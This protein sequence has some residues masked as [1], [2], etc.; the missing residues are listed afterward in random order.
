MKLM[1]YH[2]FLREQYRANRYLEHLSDDDLKQR[3]KDIFVNLLIL[4]EDGKIGHIQPN[5]EGKKWMSL[6]T[7]V[8]EEFEIRFGPFPSGFEDGFMREAKERIPQYN[9]PHLNKA[10][11]K[12]NELKLVHGNYLIKYGKYKYLS[13]TFEHGLIRISPASFYNDPSLNH[14]IR[15]SE[16]EFVLHMHPSALKMRAHDRKTGKS[17]DILPEDLISNVTYSL[18]TF[19]YYVFCLSSVYDFRLFGDFNSD[20]CLIIKDSKSFLN[21]LKVKAKDKLPNWECFSGLV[22]YIDPIKSNPNQVENNMFF[23]KHFRYAY[24]KE[25]RIVW[26]SLDI[27]NS[28]K[29]I[30]LELGSLMKFTELIKF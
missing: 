19:D 8:L 25:Y 11:N 16:L 14:A 10:V 12:F 1:Q 22:S 30:F 3:S 28:L 18:T 29:H 9:W 7:H 21:R 13:N 15:D 4:T 5:D 26:I 17:K 2:Q 6:W 23:S 27:K 20:A 24:Q